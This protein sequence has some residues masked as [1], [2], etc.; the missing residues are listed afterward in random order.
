MN[1]S[2]LVWSPSYTG[3]NCPITFTLE[4]FA[5]PAAAAGP[6]APPPP[7]PLPPLLPPPFPRSGGGFVGALGGILLMLDGNGTL[8]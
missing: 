3:G 7:P 1:S 5:D 6:G 4:G 2:D 8:T